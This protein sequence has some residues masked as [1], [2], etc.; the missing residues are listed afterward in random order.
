MSN[1]VP[2]D[3]A[4]DACGDCWVEFSNFWTDSIPTFFTESVP[5][6]F[7]ETIPAGFQ[8]AW[9]ATAL[10]V[11]DYVK[12]FFDDCKVWF[13]ENADWLWP[14]A[15]AFVA[16]AAFVGAI[17]LSCL[18]CKKPVEDDGSGDDKPQ[19]NGSV[20]NRSRTK[21]DASER[22]TESQTPYLIHPETTTRGLREHSGLEQQRVET[23]SLSVSELGEKPRDLHVAPLPQGNI[24]EREFSFL[25]PQEH[26]TDQRRLNMSRLSSSVTMQRPSAVSEEHKGGE[27][28]LSDLPSQL[29]LP[30]QNRTE[31]GRRRTGPE[32]LSTLVRRDGEQKR[33]DISSL[34]SEFASKKREDTPISQIPSFRFPQQRQ[35]TTNPQLTAVA[36]ATSTAGLSG[37]DDD[38]SSVDDEIPASIGTTKVDPTVQ[39]REDLRS[40]IQSLQESLDD[41]N[42]QLM[43]TRERLARGLLEK[44]T[45]LQKLSSSK[46][47]LELQHNRLQGELRLINQARRDL[48]ATAKAG[49]VDD[50][51]VKRVVQQINELDQEDQ[52]GLQKLNRQL[53]MLLENVNPLTWK[54]ERYSELDQN[55][56]HLNG[57]FRGQ[58]R[59]TDG[60]IQITEQQIAAL[61]EEI[62][63][64]EERGNRSLDL[65]TASIRETEA[66]IEQLRLE[67]GRLTA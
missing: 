34:L 36:A 14:V 17:A 25:N 24:S 56:K 55:L 10:W 5:T 45:S 53:Y 1:L 67:L 4:V 43:N 31:D 26:R 35:I 9:D 33:P 3:V 42:A 65:L 19:S 62:R 61:T 27:G 7:T 47:E 64:T 50:E 6:F 20:G 60:Q 16:G 58:Q 49:E 23:A 44:K 8:A 66:Q 18:C 63:E 22:S 29:T 12:P 51:D 37:S 30:T 41:K 48:I 28:S 21:S 57:S 32:I 13:E 38:E 11:D 52:N 40:E 46:E 2:A 15:V 39:R 59:I 54:R